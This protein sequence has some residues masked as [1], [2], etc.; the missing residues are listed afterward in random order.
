MIHNALIEL[1]KSCRKII[2]KIYFN[3][4]VF[5]QAYVFS[6]LMFN[7]Y[8]MNQ[9]N[10]VVSKDGITLLS[11]ATDLKHIAADEFAN[12]TDIKVG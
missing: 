6:L 9:A 12:H 7:K 3:V 8:T 11:R 1:N 10:W 4:C 5:L 2:S